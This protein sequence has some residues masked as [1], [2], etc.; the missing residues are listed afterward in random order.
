[1][2]LTCATV[3]TLL[4]ACG[5][6]EQSTASA[7]TS[8]GEAAQESPA[9]TAAW[10]YAEQV[11]LGVGAAE[12][13][14]GEPT[15]EHV[16]EA[17]EIL[18]DAAN[19][20]S[21]IAVAAEVEQ[22]EAADIEVRIRAALEPLQTHIAS[23]TTAQDADGH[24]RMLRMALQEALLVQS[25]RLSSSLGEFSAALSDAHWDAN[26]LNA[27]VSIFISAATEVA[28]MLVDGGEASELVTVR[29][30]ARDLSADVNAAPF[31]V[32]ESDSLDPVA[33]ARES[34]ARATAHAP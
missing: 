19:R 15:E 10:R 4:F 14:R 12:W 24:R 30:A 28:N 34:C 25:S 16:L 13:A 3:A 2:K 8:G 32:N 11:I 29:E 5:S 6:A 27:R 31:V 17:A 21:E 1:M 22:T 9:F 7:D 23:S 33:A 20:A 18:A 26:C